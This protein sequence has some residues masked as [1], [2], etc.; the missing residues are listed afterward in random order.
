MRN[1][2]N[3]FWMLGV[4]AVAA[5]GLL[6]AVVRVSRAADEKPPEAK[7]VVT[8]KQIMQGINNPNCGGID[9]M[10]KDKGPADDAAWVKVALQAA[11]LNE[12]GHL[13]MDNNRCPSP[14]WAEACKTLRTG[15]TGLVEAA[16]KKD[17]AAAQAAFK[18]TTAAC[19][20]CHAK[21]KKK[22]VPPLPA[23]FAEVKMLMKGINGPNYNAIGAAIKGDGP[24]DD[25]AWAALFDQAALLNEVGHLLMDNE[26]CPDGTWK[27][28]ATALRVGATKVGQAAKAKDLEAARG[29][30][31]ELVGGACGAC[32][33]A[34]KK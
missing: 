23:R 5:T 33:K 31:K 6:A 25:A 7:R 9:E 20:A 28:A 16:G 34:H 27:D 13:L 22:P 18:T 15:S 3:R 29:G 21:H 17:L 30:H 8:I 10:L 19:G 26:R 1:S 2:Q 32:H 4:T 24:Q 11:L 12:A 14:V